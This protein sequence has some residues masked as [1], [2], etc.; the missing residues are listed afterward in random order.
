M[1]P[2]ASDSSTWCTRMTHSAS[3]HSKWRRLWPH[4]RPSH[5]VLQKLA[6]ARRSRCLWTLGSH[7]SASCLLLRSAV[8]TKSKASPRSWRS[9][10]QCSRDIDDGDEEESVRRR[11]R[12][13]KAEGESVR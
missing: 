13:E 3:T 7:S 12:F 2:C 11:R 10:H 6:C 9:A 5:C 4:T 1:K 8:P